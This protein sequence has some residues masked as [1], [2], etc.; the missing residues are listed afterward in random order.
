MKNT[1][2]QRCLIN[3]D[4]D[5][6]T[7]SLSKHTALYKNCYLNPGHAMIKN[8]IKLIISI[9]VVTAKPISIIVKNVKSTD[10]FL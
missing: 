1:I 6:F 5:A 3:T 2:I 9:A 8:N 7:G 10:S 4:L